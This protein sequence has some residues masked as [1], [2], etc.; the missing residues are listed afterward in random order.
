[1]LRTVDCNIR[2]KQQN[3]QR[4]R[5]ALKLGNWNVWTMLMGLSNDMHDIDG[6]RKTA[7][8]NYELLRQSVDIA[9]LQKT[10]LADSETKDLFYE[11]LSSVIR[12]IP[13]KEQLILLGDF[14][15]RV[16][17]DND[18][19]PSCLGHSLHQRQQPKLTQK[20]AETF[21]QELEFIQKETSTEERW[22]T[23]RD[24]IHSTA[25]E[26]FALAEYKR[27]PSQKNLL[28]LRAARGKVQRMARLCANEYW[29]ELCET[30]QTAAISDLCSTQNTVTVSALEATECLPT[31]DE[32][33]VEPTLEELSKTIDN[34]ASG[35]APGN[36]G[37]PPDLLKQCKSSLLSPLHKVL[38][39]CWEDGSVPQDMRDAKIVT[40]YKTKGERSD[41]KCREQ[42]MPLY[43]SFI[44][45]T[46]AFDVL[47]RNKLFKVLP[48]IG[49]PPKLLSLVTSF[50]VDIKGTVQFNG[51]SSEPCSI[52][53]GVKQGCVC[54]HAQTLKSAI[55]SSGTCYLPTMQ[56]LSP[57]PRKNR[58]PMACEEYG[59]TISLKKTNILSQDTSTAPA[60]AIDDYQLDVVHQF[61]YLGSTI[62]DNLSLDVELDKRIGKAT[63]TLARLSK[64]VWT[65]LTLKTS[66]KMAV[67]NACIISTLLYGS[68]SWTTY[69]RQERRLNTFHLRSL[70]ASWAFHGRTMCL[71]PKSC[72]GRT[73]QAC[74]LCFDVRSWEDLAADR[75]RWRSTLL[76]QIKSREESLCIKQK[77]NVHNESSA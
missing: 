25:L 51:S 21:E 64:R 50:H 61:T 77:T 48:K 74:S 33:D 42:Q 53:S 5:P 60:I 70:R 1:M 8:I 49:C 3:V 17:T 14:N 9:A 26:A 19:W 28:S 11:K 30:I 12:N 65:N 56:Q 7:D 52:N 41:Q 72:L 20:F 76:R 29:Q 43:I 63:S 22:G 32:L 67:Y 44:D 57:T 15:A 13:D 66:T 39:E 55:D 45:L 37:I 35:K 4:K 27:T 34:L 40:L 38:C 2:T 47:S 68:E 58:F 31:M 36:D 59:L 75:P 69:S 10:R 62:T 71:T 16:G 46:K 23:L 18:S 73:L 54:P 6:S 24:I